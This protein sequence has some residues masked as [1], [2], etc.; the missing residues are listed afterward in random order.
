[1]L[2]TTCVTG[3]FFA[4]VDI[5]RADEGQISR[6]LAGPF[7][8]SDGGNTRVSYLSARDNAARVQLYL[9]AL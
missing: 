5:H 7:T 1:M 9:H 4:T 6:V 8:S 3:M 2:L